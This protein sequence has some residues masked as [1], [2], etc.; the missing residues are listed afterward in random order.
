M[1]RFWEKLGDEAKMKHF[2]HSAEK[3]IL[4][5]EKE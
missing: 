2:R 5:A 4:K 3:N 1:T